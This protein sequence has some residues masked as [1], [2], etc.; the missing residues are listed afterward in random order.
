VLQVRATQLDV[1]P[2]NTKTLPHK[3]S[4]FPGRCHGTFLADVEVRFEIF[5]VAV[6]VRDIGARPDKVPHHSG[7]SIERRQAQ[8][9]VAMAPKGFVYNINAAQH[10]R[11]V[12]RD[13]GLESGEVVVLRAPL[14]G[15]GED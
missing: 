12:C 2:C 10:G 14:R 4:I 13:N 6:Y 11:V 3:H 15:V 9:G 7:R 5:T 8:C 1:A